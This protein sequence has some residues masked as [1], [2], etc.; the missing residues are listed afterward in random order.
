[1]ASDDALDI[2]SFLLTTVRASGADA[3]DAVMFETTDISASYRLGKPEGLERAESKAVGLRVFVG[4]QQATVS[5]TDTQKDSLKELCER[6]VVM[7]R[8]AP[9]D[10]S[11][12]LAPSSL[13]AA[14][15][16]ALDLRDTN[17]PDAAWLAAQCKDA[18]EAARSVTG[19]TNSEG[20]DAHYSAS[21]IS[22]AITNGKSIGFAH[23]YD[24]SHFSLSAS[25]LAGSGTAMERD[26]DYSNAR[27]RGDLERAADIGR[28]AGQ[29]AVKRLH[30]RK[31][32]TC[33]APVVFDP[34]V[35]RG[36]LSILASAISGTAIARG[37]SFLKDNLHKPVFARGI[38]VIDDPH[39][40]RGLGSKPFDAEGV[41]NK[42]R[43]IIKN[44]EL[45]TWL[46]DMRTAN[47]LG[48]QTTGHATR[49]IASAPSPAATNLYMEK[50]EQSPAQ[51]IKGIKNGLYLTETF[52]MG[53]NTVTGDYSQGAAG[54]WIDK[55]EMA[56]PVSEITIAGNLRDMFAHL[57]AASDLEFR[58]ATNAP[59]LCVERMTIAGA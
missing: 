23:S 45:C 53:V 59:T 11:S 20:A 57:V 3:A 6:A 9:A 12:T 37:S 42:K 5:A 47:K 34:R 16:P 39:R 18:E 58:Y 7:A 22:L 10:P 21:R 35:S 8:A 43:E 28:N 26:Y 13:Y 33:H 19:V 24:S 32:A 55:G 27:H 30:P 52:G 25:V 41:A 15:L 36:L 54:F 48:L 49:G 56:Y 31:V 2:L 40:P 4:Q 14:S 1:M 51:M 38:T 17:A 29:R 44:G 50:G 46:L